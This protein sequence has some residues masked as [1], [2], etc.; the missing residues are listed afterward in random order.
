MAPKRTETSSAAANHN[1]KPYPDPSPSVASSS[2]SS[3]NLDTAKRLQYRLESTDFNIVEAKIRY[4]S[5]PTDVLEDFMLGGGAVPGEGGPALKSPKT[6]AGDVAAQMVCP[7]YVATC[8][9]HAFVLVV[10][11]IMMPDM[12][13]FSSMSWHLRSLAS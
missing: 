4:K 5:R 1:S 8:G 6:L 7:A 2:S 11:S 3:L 10:R 12:T 13:L 9:V